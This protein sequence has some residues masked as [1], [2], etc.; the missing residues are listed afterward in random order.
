MNFKIYLD[1][2]KL[3]NESLIPKE[4]D[5]DF[6]KFVEGYYHEIGTDSSNDFFK[7]FFSIS[8]N[9]ISD[10]YKLYR[11]MFIHDLMFA[12][13]KNNKFAIM[14]LNILFEKLQI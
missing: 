4:Y 10:N 7:R 11:N 1:I 3:K 6:M 14:F 2:Y 8:A 12:K 9:V 13:E 5:E